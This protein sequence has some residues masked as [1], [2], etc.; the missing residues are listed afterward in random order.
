LV[1]QRIDARDRQGEE[2]VVLEGQAEA[3]GLDPKAEEAGVP[4]K[5]FGLGGDAEA[6]DLPRIEDRIVREARGVRS[7][8][9]A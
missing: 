5:R 8:W 4:V 7:L 6:G 9:C 3:V 2:R 1:G